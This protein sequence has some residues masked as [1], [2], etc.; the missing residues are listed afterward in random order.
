MRA[1]GRLVCVL[2]ARADRGDGFTTSEL[3]QGCTPSG[4]GAPAAALAAGAQ[5]IESLHQLSPEI[6]AIVILPAAIRRPAR[7]GRRPGT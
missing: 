1:S 3:V 7:V 6:D 4:A 2:Y 5:A